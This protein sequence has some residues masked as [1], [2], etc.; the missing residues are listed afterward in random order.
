MR[1]RRRLTRRAVR[2]LPLF[3]AAANFRMFKQ[4]EALFGLGDGPLRPGHFADRFTTGA[5]GGQ[6]RPGGCLQLLERALRIVVV[7]QS[8]II[9]RIGPA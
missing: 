1:S 6:Q 9:V 2:A 5:L 8:V 4:S 3:S 7:G